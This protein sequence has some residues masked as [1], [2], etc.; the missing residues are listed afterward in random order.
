MRKFC[1]TL[2]TALCVLACGK[3]PETPE[4]V[5]VPDVPSGLRLHSATETSL[6]YQWGA[7]EG[8]TSYKWRLTLDGQTA[9]EGSVTTRNTTVS[10]LSKG[11]TYAFSVCAA[12]SAGA[13]DYCSPVE[14]TTEG[15]AVDPDVLGI[16]PDA[17]LVLEL[18]SSPTLGTSGLV[19]I[20]KSDATEVDRID[21]S[22]ISTVDILEDGT[23]LPK[24][25]ITADTKFN[26]FMDAIQGASGRWRIVHCTP[27]RVSGKTLRIKPHN[28]VLSPG[29]SYYVTVDESVCGKAVAAGE[30]TFTVNAAP[31]GATLSV[32]PDGTGDFCTLQGALSYLSNFGKNDAVT[33]ELAAGTYQELLY[34]R[35]KNNVTIKGASASQ[36]VIEYVNSEKWCTSTGGN[37]SAKPAIGNSIGKSGGRNLWLIESCDNLVIEGL[38]VQ[39]NVGSSD[40]QAECI[41]FNSSGKLTI[42]SCSLISWQDTFET[43]GEN[44]VHNSLIAGHVDFIW[45]GPAACLFEDCEIRARGTGYIIQARVPSASNVGFVFLNCRLTAESGVADGVMKL[46]RSGGSTDYYD[47]VAFIGCT[48]SSV[49][50]AVG[51]HESPAP[52]PSSATATS[53]WREYGSVDA[54]GKAITHTSKYFKT[55]TADE[56]SAYSSKSAVLGW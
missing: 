51:W 45:G 14:G 4:T 1:F 34:L 33:I 17:T 40:G 8:A 19:K 37:V 30:W 15:S 42:E 23:M 41:Y 46:G 27:L 54:S 24:T 55:L 5:A 25:A 28:G 22:D 21:L 53:G 36:T 47:N 13:S 31:S 44:Y 35:D 29:E 56:A 50:P 26:T 39:N 49:I 2:L 10:G 3:T 9:K 38:T 16:C 6:T 43:K 7:V 52:N 32:N 12:N 48:M 11:T 18:D 20:F